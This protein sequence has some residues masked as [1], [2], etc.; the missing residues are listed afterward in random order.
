[1]SEV[2]ALSI[3]VPTMK[4][5]VDFQKRLETIASHKGLAEESVTELDSLFSSLQHRAFRGEL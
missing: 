3:P 2:R 4:C 5:Q 1:M